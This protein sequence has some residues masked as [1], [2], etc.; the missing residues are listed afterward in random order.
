MR[1][2]DDNST[3][4]EGTDPEDFLRSIEGLGSEHWT[5][6]FGSEPSAVDAD[7]DGARA[8]QIDRQ[9]P[10]TGHPGQAAVAAPAR[11]GLPYNPGDRN[12]T[13]R[14]RSPGD[15]GVHSHGAVPTHTSQVYR[16]DSEGCV[17]RGPVRSVHPPADAM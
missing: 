7:L 1:V 9:R 12:R 4:T 8:P 3:D 6:G 11:P 13:P 5:E 14:D 17:R 10:V 16:I 2:T 15:R